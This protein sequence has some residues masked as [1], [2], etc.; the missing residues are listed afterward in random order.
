MGQAYESADAEQKCASLGPEVFQVLL[1]SVI[2]L[3]LP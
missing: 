1:V 2:V 3:P